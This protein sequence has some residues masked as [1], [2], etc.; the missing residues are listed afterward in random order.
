MVQYSTVSW[1]R[2][3]YNTRGK[4]HYWCRYPVLS[5]RVN[6]L[7]ATVTLQRTASL[8]QTDMALVCAGASLLLFLWSGTR[9]GVRGLERCK[10]DTDNKWWVSYLLVY[11]SSPAL[12]LFMN[13]PS[14]GLTLVIK[15]WHRYEPRKNSTSS[16]AYYLVFEYLLLTTPHDLFVD[17]H[18]MNPEISHR[19][20]W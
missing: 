17:D 10:G 18:H 6:T 11:H 7:L 8:Y 9:I 13:P 19:Q 2:K 12:V 16:Q 14:L 3:S 4:G 5:R 20:S 1:R 15:P